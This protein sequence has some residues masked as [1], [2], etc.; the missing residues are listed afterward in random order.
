MNLNVNLEKYSINKLINYI[1][2][3]MGTV[4]TLEDVTSKIEW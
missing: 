2:Y 1:I 3:I 4:L